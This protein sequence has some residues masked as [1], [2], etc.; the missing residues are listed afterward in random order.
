M[1]NE[2]NGTEQQGRK[3]KKKKHNGDGD[4]NVSGQ[5]S[6]SYRKE[7]IKQV[8][9][10]PDLAKTYKK[11]FPSDKCH[12]I[13][14]S[15]SSNSKNKSK[16]NYNPLQNSLQFIHEIAGKDSLK[17][18]HVNPL[19]RKG[20]NVS[21]GA[22]S[23]GLPAKQLRTENSEI[24]E[25]RSIVKKQ[26]NR[27][28]KLKKSVVELVNSEV[29][30]PVDSLKKVNDK[31]SAQ[32]KKGKVNE[33]F[34]PDSDVQHEL[35]HSVSQEP[36]QLKA[37]SSRKNKASQR[38]ATNKAFSVESSSQDNTISGDH[39]LPKKAKVNTFLQNQNPKGIGNDAFS[40]DSS[41]QDGSFD[42]NHQVPKKL[43]NKGHRQKQKPEGI[44]NEAFSADS[45]LQ[46]DS[47]SRKHKVPKKQKI[48]GPRQKPEGIV[49]EAFRDD[50][51]IVEDDNIS[52]HQVPE[53]VKT[54][55]WHILDNLRCGQSLSGKK[56]SGASLRERMITKLKASRFR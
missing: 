11:Q 19:K 53:Q 33:A 9:L 28:R 31:G 10:P 51:S 30:T 52:G 14:D 47:F 13:P 41:L 49:N 17:T 21:A 42:S 23:D 26:R 12:V 48:K 38:R 16:L 40:A 44:V 54:P 20:H 1:P 56:L 39:H 3:K 36:K 29:N 43:K 55:P 35:F 7:T 15:N 18:L 34:S 27:K 50:P 8:Q 5:L 22:G 37:K 4:E 25:S 24:Y 6:S 32:K 46:D 2:L 45:S